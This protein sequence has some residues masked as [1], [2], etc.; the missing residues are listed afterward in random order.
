MDKRVFELIK[1]GV[2]SCFLILYSFLRVQEVLWY[3]S[4]RDSLAGYLIKLAVP[5]L[6]LLVGLYLV[7]LFKKKLLA[8]PEDEFRFLSAAVRFIGGW[9]VLAMVLKNIITFY[10][11]SITSGGVQL[12]AFLFF[13][14]YYCPILIV[15]VIILKKGSL[16]NIDPSVSERIK[17]L[18]L[19]VVLIH[20]CIICIDQI[21]VWFGSFIIMAPYH[22][23]PAE[24]NWVVTESLFI[25]LFLILFFAP[26][27]L[28]LN[29]KNSDGQGYNAL[30]RQSFNLAG[31][32]ILIIAIPRIYNAVIREHGPFFFFFFDIKEFLVGLLPVL[33]LIASG[34]IFIF[35]GKKAEYMKF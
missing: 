2:C 30:S 4:S 29:L 6:M 20:I 24:R 11:L 3:S 17:Y 13:L 33:F 8:F 10:L 34:L 27:R 25:A 21:L 14:I 9:V 28:K 26:L 7:K 22:F 32:V 35:Y 19:R 5:V 18:C 23:S 31:Y 16:R 1:I 12:R 15:S